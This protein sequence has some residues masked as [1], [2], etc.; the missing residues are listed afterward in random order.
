MNTD[1]FRL[2]WENSKKLK[3]RCPKCKAL[4]VTEVKGFGVCKYC[5]TKV[6]G[7]KAKF[8]EKLKEK[9]ESRNEK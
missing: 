4:V 8:K 3:S 5:G 7:H 6:L 1:S 9:L 2:G